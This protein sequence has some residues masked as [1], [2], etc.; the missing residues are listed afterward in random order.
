MTDKERI[1][2]LEEIIERPIP[3]KVKR[4]VEIATTNDFHFHCMHNHKVYAEVEE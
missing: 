1:A 2:E 3:A 4:K